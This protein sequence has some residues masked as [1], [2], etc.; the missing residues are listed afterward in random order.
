MSLAVLYLLDIFYKYIFHPTKI[1]T[2]KNFA[3]YS[4]KNNKNHEV[5]LVSLETL[6]SIY[7][8]KWI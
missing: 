7:Y 3:Y 8:V 1:N 5:V 4:L 2:I 6:F